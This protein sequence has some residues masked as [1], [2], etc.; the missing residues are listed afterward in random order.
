MKLNGDDTSLGVLSVRRVR[1]V[2]VRACGDTR[3]HIAVTLEWVEEHE[4]GG[5]A[6]DEAWWGEPASP[7]CLFLSSQSPVETEPR[8]QSL[9]EARSSKHYRTQ[10]SFHH[11]LETSAPPNPR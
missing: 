4:I 9:K 6:V 8:A 2:C 10:T 1:S 7:P 5:S 3:S 11:V